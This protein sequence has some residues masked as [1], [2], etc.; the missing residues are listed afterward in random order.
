[1][2]DTVQYS[3]LFYK[4]CRFLMVKGTE[5]CAK[6][7]QIP[8]VVAGEGSKLLLQ[9]ICSNMYIPYTSKL[10][11]WFG[12]SPTPPVSKLNRRHTVRLRKRDNLLTGEGG[13][14]EVD[15]NPNHSTAKSLVLYK[16][17]NTLWPTPL[18]TTLLP[19]LSLMDHKADEKWAHLAPKHN[20]LQP[21]SY[22]SD[23][24][25]ALPS[26]WLSFALDT[27]ITYRNG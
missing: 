2:Y 9:K 14:K 15:E 18:L 12:S 4:M 13:G 16:P 8:Y 24:T 27:I 19:L 23:P 3:S 26:H 5:V 21:F 17:F 7:K 25:W 11:L 6:L 10:W 22:W 1:M 20:F